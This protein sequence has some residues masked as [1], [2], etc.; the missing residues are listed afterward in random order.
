MDDF[1]RALSPCKSVKL[2]ETYAAREKFNEAGSYKKLGYKL[3]NATLCDG[4]EGIIN[5]FEDDKT[6]VSAY[7]VLGAG[8]LYDKVKF[9]LK[10]EQCGEKTKKV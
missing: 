1:V 3:K 6:Q 8:D 2:F 10:E 4:E 9:F 7:V 5:A